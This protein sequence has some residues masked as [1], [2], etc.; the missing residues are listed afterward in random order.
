MQRIRTALWPMQKPAGEAFRGVYLAAPR[1]TNYLLPRSDTPT[2]SIQ[3]GKL[4]AIS[5]PCIKLNTFGQ[6]FADT[7]CHQ[8]PRLWLTSSSY[9]LPITNTTCRSFLRP[10]SGF[11]IFYADESHA[12]TAPSFR[13]GEASLEGRSLNLLVRAHHCSSPSSKSKSSSL[14]RW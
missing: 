8:L 2:D 1:W 9:Q 6:G 5:Q 7:G 14:L 3:I 13:Y 12:S 11:R 10:S 4:S